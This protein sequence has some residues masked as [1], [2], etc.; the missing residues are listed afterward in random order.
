M[1]N[2]SE[3]IV[4]NEEEFLKNIPQHIAIIM[5]GN[6]RW[7]KKRTLPRI[8]GHKEG[9]NNVKTIAIAANKLGVKVLTL[10]AFSTENWGRPSTEVN[11]LM[12][13]PVDF[14]GVFMPDLMK[15]NIKVIATGLI[16]KVPKKTK[17]VIQQAVE[18]T[19][20]NTGMQLNFAFNYGGRADIIEATKKIA[21]EVAD[22]KIKVEDITDDV[23][24]KSLLTSGLQ[25]LADPDL[26]IRTSGEM[27]ISNFM[28]WQLAYTEMVFD[29]VFWPD[30]TSDNLKNDILEYQNRNRRFGKLK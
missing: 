29:D 18:A 8:A 13:L 24:E 27:R 7:A 22:S 11:F 16:E 5:D 1:S 3:F 30:Y 25:E 19:K 20:N 21:Q 9:M 28:L 17:E 10:Y 4:E 15:N 6:G 2:N 14:F 26:L 23:F 12:K